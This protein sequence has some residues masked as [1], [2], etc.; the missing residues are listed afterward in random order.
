[1]TVY[2]DGTHLVADTLDELH[3]FA[4]VMGL[5]RIWFQD[6]ISHPHYDLT[7]ARAK[8]RALGRGAVKVSSKE[9]VIIAHKMS[10]CE[11]VT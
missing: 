8:M 4:Y 1:M 7:T 2:T 5:K 10:K 11:R 3:S 6:H 9:L